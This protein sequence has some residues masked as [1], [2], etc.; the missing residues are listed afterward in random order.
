MLLYRPKL[1]QWDGPFTV[2]DI[3]HKDISVLLP[4]SSG[5]TKFQSTVVKR[6][7]S[8]AEAKPTSDSSDLFFFTNLISVHSAS[9]PCCSPEDIDN[10]GTLLQFDASSSK[11]D[12]NCFGTARAI[13]FISLVERSVFSLIPTDHAIGHRIFSSRNPDLAKNE[14][15]ANG[16]QKKLISRPSL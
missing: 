14:V 12:D 9:T 4:N 5:P 1:E 6:F 13:E 10:V 16:V 7:V 11:Y 3:A 2:L 15:R 8:P